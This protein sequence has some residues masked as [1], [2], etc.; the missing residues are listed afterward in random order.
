MTELWK[1]FLEGQLVLDFKEQTD[2]DIK[3]FCNSVVEAVLGCKSLYTAENTRAKLKHYTS[4]GA[5][6]YAFK[7]NALVDG[8]HKEV[9]RMTLAEFLR[10][11]KQLKPV[12]EEE[13]EMFYE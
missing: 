1:R 12:T 11:G 9:E 4:I 5:R 10:G 3:T 2:K 8:T 6:Y 13:M 7:D